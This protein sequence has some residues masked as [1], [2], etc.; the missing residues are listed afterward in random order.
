MRQQE[1]HTPHVRLMKDVSVV[2][3][4]HRPAKKKRGYRRSKGAAADARPIVG[5]RT[6][7]YPRIRG[8]GIQHRHQNIACRQKKKVKKTN[9]P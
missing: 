4:L 7:S 3:A 9:K 1:A 8:M 5:A 6:T 2:G